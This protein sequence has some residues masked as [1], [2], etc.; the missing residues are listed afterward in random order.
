MLVVRSFVNQNEILTAVEITELRQ[1]EKILQ[2]F[3]A[4]QKALEGLK[5]VSN[6]L[7]PYIVHTIRNG[8]TEV[9]NNT[10]DQGIK[11]LVQNFT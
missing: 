5:Y 6:S 3:M 8:L 7:I 1:L 4:A 10:D 11:E 9:F 2:P